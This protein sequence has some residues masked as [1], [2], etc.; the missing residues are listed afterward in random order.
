M[1]LDQTH[2]LSVSVR[3]H[4]I[5]GRGDAPYVDLVCLDAAM[6]ATFGAV[7]AE[8]ATA[9]VDE[10][11]GQRTNAVLNAVRNWRWFW[12]VDPGQLSVTDAVGLFGEL[13][14]LHRWAGV[15]AGNVTAWGGSNGARHDFQW[16]TTSIE[17]KT[18]SRTTGAVVHTIE[19]L[20]QLEDPASGE[21]YLYSLRIARDVLAANSVRGL[22]E[23]AL[24]LL[25][26]DPAARADLMGKL[27]AR[28][29][30]PVG[31]G[32]GVTTYRV[33]EEALYRVGDGFPRVTSETF[34]AGLPHGVTGLSYQLD[35]TACG[36]WRTDA[37]PGSWT[38]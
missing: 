14:F 10:P 6:Q 19:N 15:T 17:V 8:I 2:G 31:Q 26:P 35:M 1:P 38:P 27:A 33:V 34:A 23:S 18:T 12:G 5:A 24:A 25:Q 28:G 3:C 30:T 29:Y 16:P 9:V 32:Q 4:S 21:L 20:Q 37:T 7:A 11:T 36:A 13:W 22:A